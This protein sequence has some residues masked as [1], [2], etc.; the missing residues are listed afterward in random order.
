MMSAKLSS[1][2]PELDSVALRSAG[3]SSRESERGE[4]REKQRRRNEKN[5]TE[6]ERWVL[7]ELLIAELWEKDTERKWRKDLEGGDIKV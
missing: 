7:E 6:I 3:R 1:F 4:R 2:D 5:K